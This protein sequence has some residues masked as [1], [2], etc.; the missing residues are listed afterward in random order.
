VFA[1]VTELFVAV[2]IAFV[3]TTSIL[4]FIIL[5]AYAR[6]RSRRMLFITIGFG[7]FF[8][9]GLLSVPEV[10]SNTYDL[11]FTDSLHILADLA[12]L[13]FILLGTVQDMFFRKTQE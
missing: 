9:H 3:V 13:V 8:V 10:I 6:F 12:G 1:L 11:Y 7:L 4:F 5:A 2:R